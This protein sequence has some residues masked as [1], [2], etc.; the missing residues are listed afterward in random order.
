MRI[1]ISLFNQAQLLS[2][3]LIQARFH[4]ESEKE[5]L[6]HPSMN[7]TNGCCIK[8]KTASTKWVKTRSV[9]LHNPHSPTAQQPPET[10]HCFSPNSRVHE[11]P[12]GS[13]GSTTTYSLYLAIRV[14]FTVYS[15][16]GIM[17]NK[18]FRSPSQCRCLTLGRTQSLPN[19]YL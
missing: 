10:W 19:A 5:Q 1:I 7:K 4:T 3:R 12:P 13:L 15:I 8:S 6:T 9:I 11:E 16:P 18:T 2:L 14:S 17:D